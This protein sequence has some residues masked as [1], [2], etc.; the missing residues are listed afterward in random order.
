MPMD[1]RAIKIRLGLILEG[2]VAE[3]LRQTQFNQFESTPQYDAESMTPDFLIPNAD[4]PKYFVEVTQT[5]TRDSFRMK[6]LRYFEAVCEAK[7]YLGSHVVSVNILMGDPSREL[8]DSNVQ[9]MYGYFDVNLC[10][11]NDAQTDCERALLDNLEAAALAVAADESIENVQSGLNS[12]LREN[13]DAIAVLAEMLEDSITRGS[14]RAELTAVWDSERERLQSISARTTPLAVIAPYKRPVLE[15]LLISDEDFEEIRN[16]SRLS[17]LDARVIRELA[18]K[19]LLTLRRVPKKALLRVFDISLDDFRELIERKTVERFLAEI[20]ERLTAAGLI[21]RHPAAA[22]VV[23]LELSKPVEGLLGNLGNLP[24]NDDLRVIAEDPFGQD[25]REMCKKRVD[26]E[27]ENRWFFEDIRSENRRLRMAEIYLQKVNGGPEVLFQALSENASSGILEEIEH[28]RCWIA[29]LLACHV[30]MSH[31]AFNKAMYSDPGYLGSLGGPFNFLT[32]RSGSILSR[33]EIRDS[34]LA[35]AFSAYQH[36]VSI[37]QPETINCGQ[38]ALATRLLELRLGALVK[39]HSLNPLEIVI[40]ETCTELGLDLEYG[41]IGNIVSDASS[42]PGSAGHYRVYWATSG[43]RKV[44]INALYVDEYGGR[45][46]A[47]EWAARGRSFLYRLSDG[48]VLVSNYTAMVMVLD[49][50]WHSESVGKLER[51]GW[52]ACRPADLASVLQNSL[53]L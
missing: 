13:S 51:S 16:V 31:N 20:C 34:V 52:V 41:T 39:R 12:V 23:R 24:L 9:A 1:E 38:R 36:F 32:I 19:A 42:D 37:A 50:P 11:R 45:D 47:K 4:T 8:T 25:I 10:P 28:T 15:G 26:S 30:G 40:E 27:P 18:G 29:D 21:E 5:D 22:G 43:D 49:G 14:V 53:D 33:S 17:D 48:R 7:A 6:T 2:C 3:A 44:L 35:T 46:K